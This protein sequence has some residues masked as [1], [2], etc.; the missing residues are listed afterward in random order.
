[1]LRFSYL[2]RRKGRGQAKGGRGT[3]VRCLLLVVCMFVVLGGATG[4]AQTLVLENMVVDNTNG[5]MTLHYGVHFRDVQKV[6]AALDEGLRLRFTSQ[7]SLFRKRSLWL[8]EFL[9]Q[10]DFSC[11]LRLDPLT[12]EGV[13]R[14]GEKETRFPVSE[15]SG[16][17]HGELDHLVA[18]LGPWSAV[19]KDNDY[20]IRLQLTLQRVG[21]PAWIRVPLFF[22]SWDLVPEKHFEMEFAY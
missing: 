13:L 2:F 10:S 20:V 11:D 5:T 14:I 4:W 6:R 22:W 21:I 3:A 18:P 8:D 7:A 16:I 17:L 1:M 19:E 15:F 9:A 12:Q